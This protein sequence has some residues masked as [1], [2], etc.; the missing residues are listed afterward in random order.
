MLQDTLLPTTR[1]GFTPAMLCLL[2]LATSLPIFVGH[3][4]NFALLLGQ[5]GLEQITRPA[6]LAGLNAWVLGAILI[7]I[8]LALWLWPRRARP[9]PLPRL[10]VLIALVQA[11]T[12]VAM[13]IVYGPLT[14]PIT[15]VMI[16]ALVIGLALLGRRP[17]IIGFVVA[18]ILLTLNDW[19]VLGGIVPYAPALVPG[20]FVE[21]MPVLWWRQWQDFTFFSAIIFGIGLIVLL[22][23]HL[24]RQRLQLETLS[25]SDSL[26]LLSN[27]RHFMERLGIERHR[28]DRYRQSFCVVL[29]D[30]D[31]F[32]RVND[33]W[34][35]HVGDEVL[36][37]VGR[38]LETG[39]RIPG[40]VAARL[41]GE[42]FALLLTDCR[43][44]EAR[45]VC[46]RLRRQIAAQAF[47]GGAE[48][49]HVTLSMGVVE[50]RGGS[51]EDALRQADLNLYRAKAEGRDCVITSVLEVAP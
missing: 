45:A 24:D 4:A 9:E 18:I 6:V 38:L 10:M 29:C 8:A 5:S 23:A 50:C 2:T 51:D 37:Q 27:R 49:F 1:K 30:A 21:G 12:Y 7:D 39:L 35:H 26:T 34:G 31:H 33:S 28:R 17:T 22:F 25:R 13:G 14:S 32:K 48:R 20:T 41:G 40:D 16:S 47:E 15:T 3:W 19:L 44:S 46:E 42:E 36:R 11:I 43:E